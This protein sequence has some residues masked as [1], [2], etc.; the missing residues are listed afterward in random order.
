MK[1]KA[2]L[3]GWSAIAIAIIGVL[4]ALRDV[5]AMLFVGLGD[6]PQ[7]LRVYS[8]TLII[9]PF[10]FALILFAF[11]LAALY[12]KPYARKL[13]LTYAYGQYIIAAL[14]AFGTYRML[15]ESTLLL[16]V[17]AV[18]WIPISIPLIYAIVL[19]VYYNRKISESQQGVPGYRR[20]SAPQPE[21]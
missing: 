19:T 1:D 14:R 15:S 3:I 10:I 12:T 21:R 9:L 18:L 11:G 8:I 5:G 7:M 13:A 6:T 20:Q 4:S 2:K 16:K 17:V